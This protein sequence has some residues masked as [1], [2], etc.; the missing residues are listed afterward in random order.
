MLMTGSQIVLEVLAE[1][2]VDTVFGYPGGTILNVYDALYD[3]QLGIRHFITA[4]E[5]GAAHAADGYA[6]ATGKTGVV[7]ATSGPGSTNLVTGIATAFMDSIPMVAI[8]ANVPNAQIG[9]D[10]FQEVYITGITMPITKHNFVV[11]RVEDLADTIRQAFSIANSGRPGPVLVDIPKDVTA[12]SCEFLPA[13]APAAPERPAEIDPAVIAEVAA[14]INAAER[15]VIHFGGGVIGS[16]ASPLIYE[17]AHRASIPACHT[18]MGTGVL[19]YNDPLNMG[20]VGMHGN[21]S[22]GLAI[23]GADLLLVIGARFSDRVATKPSDFA[24]RARIVQIDIDRSEI[25]KN[26]HIDYSI[27]GDV[28]RV[29]EAV[30]PLIERKE[31]PAWQAQIDAWRTDDVVPPASA[32]DGKLHPYDIIHAV[33]E[34]AGEDAIIVT[35]VGQ[36]Q[37]W[38]A[39]YCGRTQPRSFLTSGGLGTMGF[40]YGAAIGAQV[41][42]PKRRVIHITGDGCFHMNLNELCT[43]V[44]YNLPVITV[45]LNN[46]VLGMVRQWQTLFYD[47][48]YSSTSL[49]RKTDFAKV[50][51]AFGAKGFHADTAEEFR[52]KFSKA[53]GSGAPCVIECRIDEDEMVMPMIPGGS[54]VKEAYR[55]APVVSEL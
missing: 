17:L 55:S 27:V 29:L 8:T 36:H 41:A 5:Q 42:F 11:R 39:Q 32:L 44:S 15:P 24:R 52:E 12:A 31:H 4:H 54:T 10:S 7:F 47:H 30:L 23:N 33:A 53:L 38:A 50:A 18:I 45:V 6:R 20:M 16:G 1:E 43:S 35:D 22:A 21:I 40:G 19:S 51:E 48:R 2:K 9:S 34:L 46:G 25:N 3:N 28:G 37:M 26:I 13:P 14:L 49:H